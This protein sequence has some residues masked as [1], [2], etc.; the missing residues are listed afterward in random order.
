MKV[1]KPGNMLPQHVWV[2]DFVVSNS[3]KIVMLYDEMS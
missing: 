2:T 3:G 1:S